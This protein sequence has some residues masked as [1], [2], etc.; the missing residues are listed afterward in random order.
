MR[1]VVDTL[2]SAV[3]ERNEM[4][5][6]ELLN[7]VNTEKPNSF[8]NE[9][10]MNLV[11]EV[12]AQV[13]D[14]LET[15]DSMRIYHVRSEIETVEEPEEPGLDGELLMPDPYSTAYESY[16]RARLDYANEEFDLYANDTEQFNSD[17]DSWKA[18]AMRHG[19]VDTSDLPTKITNWW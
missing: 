10:L 2:S 13:Y 17:M 9:Y 18:Y 3:F 14:Y 16:I 7:K 1:K 15:P 12:E 6:L 19:Q 11:N 8:S 5:L 4:T